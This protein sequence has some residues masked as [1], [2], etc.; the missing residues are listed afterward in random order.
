MPKW[1]SKL[2][3]SEHVINHSE[4]MFSWFTEITES[5]QLSTDSRETCGPRLIIVTVT[6]CSILTYPFVVLLSLTV[7]RDSID[8]NSRGLLPSA[9]DSCLL[10]LKSDHLQD[11]KTI[12]FLPSMA[13]PPTKLAINYST[14]RMAF[15]RLNGMAFA[16]GHSSLQ[17]ISFL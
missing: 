7:W 2:I 15:T 10:A 6:S 17:E 3:I 1:L 8:V 11:E 5:I 4:L 9:W 14:T 16:W 12:S 13:W